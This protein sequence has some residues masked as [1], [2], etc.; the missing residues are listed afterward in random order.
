MLTMKPNTAQW[1]ARRIHAFGTRHTRATDG[2]PPSTHPRYTPDNPTLPLLPS[3]P[4]PLFP[5]APLRRCSHQHP[6]SSSMCFNFVFWRGEV[7]FLAHEDTMAQLWPIYVNTKQTM[8]RPHCSTRCGGRNNT[9]N[10]VERQQIFTFLIFN[11]YA[12]NAY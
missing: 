3:P 2:N 7:W 6:G 5:T 1:A 12:Q 8:W 11:F 10:K 9:R 4:P